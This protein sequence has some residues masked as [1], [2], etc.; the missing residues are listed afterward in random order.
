[1][2][3]PIDIHNME[4][5]RVFKGYDPEEVDDFLADIVLKYEAVYQENRKLRQSWKTCV[6]R[7]AIRAAENKM[8]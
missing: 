6:R 7:R 1:M 5:K 2:L 8:F 3:K 4:F